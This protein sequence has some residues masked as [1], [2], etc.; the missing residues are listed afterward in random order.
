M[1]SILRKATAIFRCFF[2]GAEVAVLSGKVFIN[3]R[4]EDDQG[5]AGRLYDRLEAEF[6]AG[7][8]FMDVEGHIKGGDD[9]VEILRAQVAECDVLLAIVGPRWLS[10]ADEK[11]RRRLDNP[12]DW[13]RVEL[14]GALETG[15]RVIPVLVGGAQLP[16]AEDLPGALQPLTRRQAIR[17]TPDRFK[18]DAQ[19]L[20]SQIK[21]A[22]AEVERARA[23]ATQAERAAV[24]EAER[25]RQAEEA[26]R[27]AER[28]RQEAERVRQQSLAGL[29][30]EEIN[31]ALELENWAFV[32]DKND[33][34]ELRD[35]IARFA[36]GPTERFAAE[37]LA[38]L[39]WTRLDRADKGALQ[40]FLGEFPKAGEAAVAQA[41]LDAILGREA[42]ASAAA[43]RQAEETAEWAAVAGRTDEVEIEAFLRAWPDGT[44]AADA[45][46]R[47]RELRAAGRVSVN[48]YLLGFVGAMLGAPLVALFLEAAA[49]KWRGP[50][51]SLWHSADAVSV[52][53]ACLVLAVWSAKGA[54][55]SPNRLIAFA[56]SS[57][58]CWS[59]LWFATFAVVVVVTADYGSVLALAALTAAFAGYVLSIGQMLRRR[60]VAD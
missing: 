22:L 57:A 8:L 32:K 25:R 33:P 23:A 21:S 50:R 51:L 42:E 47:L 40:A 29:T 30:P 48:P 12:E 44:H 58:A 56:I 35:H 20:V 5:N 31:R 46:A 59:A 54:V 3:Y 15:K 55:R 4:R 14:V 53:A 16:R 7:Q 49:W 34:A 6:G 38:S 37:R 27:L 45:K 13:V 39:V 17:I 9:F 1:R 2:R 24:A 28:K 18:A 60:A 10:I 11:G 43:E 52:A 19:G 36:G 26:A 41:A